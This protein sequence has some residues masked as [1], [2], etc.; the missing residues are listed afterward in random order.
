MLWKRGC[1]LDLQV[2]GLG[3]GGCGLGLGLGAV[4]LALALALGVV[5]LLTS[6]VT[7]S[8]GAAAATGPEVL[9]ECHM[10]YFPALP[11]LATNP[12][13]ATAHTLCNGQQSQQNRGIANA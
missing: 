8:R 4:T 12:G 11:L 3:L 6:L 2:C 5:A 1:V 7:G 9:H 10:T 13:D